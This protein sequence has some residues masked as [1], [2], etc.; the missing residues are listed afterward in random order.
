MLLA[1]ACAVLGTIT[2]LAMTTLE[3]C[4][5]DEPADTPPAA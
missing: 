1:A 3:G 2:V 4:D 5:C